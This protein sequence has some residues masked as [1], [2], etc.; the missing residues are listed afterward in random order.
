MA[1]GYLLSEADRQKLQQLINDRGTTRIQHIAQDTIL[2]APEV[3][4]AKVQSDP[5]SIPAL[6]KAG[7]GESY[8]HPGYASCDIYQIHPGIESAN[9]DLT[10]ISKLSF[11]VF[12]LSTS[13]ITDDWIL[14]IRS[15]SGYW[16]ASTSIQGYDCITGL[17][18]AAVTDGNTAITIDNIKVLRGADPREDTSSSS[19][20]LT[21]TKPSSWTADENK[22]AWLEWNKTDE[23]WDAYQLDGCSV[24]S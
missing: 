15:K 9:W 17:T 5:G 11:P 18:T 10:P 16:I 21:G 2:G 19:E 22:K 6:V 20:T 7:E 4:I 14:V 8:D 24:P 13:E 3:Y 1:D 12:N 23:T